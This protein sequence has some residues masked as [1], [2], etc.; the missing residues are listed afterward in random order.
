MN[1]LTL[2]Q[3]CFILASTFLVSFVV[4]FVVSF[5]PTPPFLDVPN[6][7]F[8]GGVVEAATC[9]PS[10]PF[11][12]VERVLFRSRVRRCRFPPPLCSVIIALDSSRDGKCF[13][14]PRSLPP[15]LSPSHTKQITSQFL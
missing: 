9:F 7:S 15:H 5:P 11:P 1:K 10:S 3:L 4:S 8:D 13:S 6:D 12:G 2:T 14:I